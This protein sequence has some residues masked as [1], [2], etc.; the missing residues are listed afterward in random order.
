MILQ[1]VK[2]RL[3]DLQGLAGCINAYPGFFAELTAHLHG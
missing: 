3:A 2:C 1:S